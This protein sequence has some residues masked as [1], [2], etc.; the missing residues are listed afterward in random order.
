VGGKSASASVAA[1]ACSNGTDPRGCRLPRRPDLLPALQQNACGCHPAG[2]GLLRA[3][4]GRPRPIVR[5][6]TPVPHQAMLFIRFARSVDLRPGAD[7]PCGGSSPEFAG[8]FIRCVYRRAHTLA[9]QAAFAAGSLWGDLRNYSPPMFTPLN[10][11]MV[12]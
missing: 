1:A 6:W 11:D 4:Y 5:R 10:V 2:Q 8:A 3:W 7:F 12:W 9:R